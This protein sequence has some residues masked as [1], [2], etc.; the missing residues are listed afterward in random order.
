MTLLSD[1]FYFADLMEKAL[2]DV[3]ALK[4]QQ[5]NKCYELELNPLDGKSESVTYLNNMMVLIK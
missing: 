4:T 3:K 2:D 5:E 1:F